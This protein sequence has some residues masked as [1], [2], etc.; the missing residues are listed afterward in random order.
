MSALGDLLH[1]I[2]DVAAGDGKRQDLHDE[3]D[4]LDG[5]AEAAPEDEASP[6]PAPEGVPAEAAAPE[7]EPVQAPEAAPDLPT[8]PE[9]AAFREWQDS[10]SQAAVEPVDEQPQV[11]EHVQEDGSA[12]ADA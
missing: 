9:L 12:E 1:K 6:E 5:S 8:A 10:L 4:D 3:I 7:P 11:Q 2:V